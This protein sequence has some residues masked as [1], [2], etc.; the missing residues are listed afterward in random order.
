MKSLLFFLNL[1]RQ[2]LQRIILREIPDF[3][4]KIWVE[5]EIG[6][7][8]SKKGKNIKKDRAKDYIFGHIL[9]NDLTME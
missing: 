8:I 2:L 9:A 1:P 6:I 7:V 3:G 5:A 4:C